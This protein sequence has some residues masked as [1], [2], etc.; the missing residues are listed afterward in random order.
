M[1]LW[2][3]PCRAL[4]NLERGVFIHGSNYSADHC[5][6]YYYYCCCCGVRCSLWSAAF[7]LNY[8]GFGGR[9]GI[10]TTCLVL[11]LESQPN[12]LLSI[13]KG[14]FFP[15]LLLF[16]FP[17]TTNFLFRLSAPFPCTDR[18]PFSFYFSL[19]AVWI[20]ELPLLVAGR[21]RAFERTGRPFSA[22]G[23]WYYN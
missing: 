5:C 13:F 10:H 23:G 17:R 8:S 1:P 16:L 18:A 20:R 3:L 22:G 2:R 9:S 11:W 7:L 19:F 12:P 15:I 4:V 21:K 6:R 14:A